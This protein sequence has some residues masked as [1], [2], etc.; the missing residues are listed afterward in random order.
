MQAKLTASEDLS[1]VRCSST[2]SADSSPVRI[3]DTN[4]KTA[5]G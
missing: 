2:P 3:I 4:P 1:L 5:E